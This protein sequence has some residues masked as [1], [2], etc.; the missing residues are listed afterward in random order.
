MDVFVFLI[1]TMNHCIFTSHTLPSDALVT[2]FVY[3]TD[4]IPIVFDPEFGC[5]SYLSMISFL[6]RYFEFSKSKTRCKTYHPGIIML[7]KEMTR[8]PKSL[9]RCDIIT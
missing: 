6:E 4:V 1:L 8:I 3:Y 9:S 2:F 5:S 7:C